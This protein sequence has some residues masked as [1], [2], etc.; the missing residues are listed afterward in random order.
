MLVR[1]PVYVERDKLVKAL[2]SGRY[3]QITH[4]LEHGRTWFLSRPRVC[5]LGLVGKEFPHLCSWNGTT[6][7]YPSSGDVNRYFEFEPFI[8]HSEMNDEDGWSFRRFAHAIENG[9][10]DRKP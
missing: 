1:N 5:F 6:L 9:D 10:F 3:K 8:S 2:R 7:M 4:R